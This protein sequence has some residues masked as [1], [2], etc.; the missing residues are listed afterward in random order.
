MNKVTTQPDDTE[1]TVAIYP[2][3]ENRMPF[4]I[5]MIQTIGSKSPTL[6]A[7]EPERPTLEPC[8]ELPHHG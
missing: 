5:V 7:V 1:K 3:E 8:R 6:D 2:A 4:D